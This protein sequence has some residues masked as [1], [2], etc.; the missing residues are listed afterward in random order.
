[1]VDHIKPSSLT[2][3]LVQPDIRTE[4]NVAQAKAQQQSTA[5]HSA[6]DSKQPVTVSTQIGKH[7]ALSMADAAN[8]AENP[9]VEAVKQQI[10]AGTYQINYDL[11][12]NKITK[13]LFGG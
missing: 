9:R 11:L 6:N 7:V 8:T 3:A 13:T 4:K 2:S 10:Q 12:A 5:N 1:M